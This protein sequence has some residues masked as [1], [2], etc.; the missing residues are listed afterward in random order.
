MKLH[1]SIR[2]R[3]AALFR[4]S[5]LNA[6]MDDELATR[7]VSNP[8]SGDL[9]RAHLI[10]TARLGLSTYRGKAIRDGASLSGKWA[11][12]RRAEHIII[13]AA[14]TQA[15]WERAE[16]P[17]LMVYRGI[18][19]PA[20]EELKPRAIP[21]TSATFS[22]A[23]AESHFKGPRARALFAGLGAHSFL[24]LESPVSAAFGLVLG[25][26]AHAV[27]WP[28]PQG[29]AQS[30]ADA[31]LACL[32]EAGGTVTTN[33][34][35]LSLRE[36]GHPDLTLLDVTPRQLL[37]IGGAEIPPPVSILLGLYFLKTVSDGDLGRAERVIYSRDAA[38]LLNPD[39]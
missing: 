20:Q 12:R 18:G 4:R 14:F 23:I 16:R 7:Y 30:I 2:L 6:D 34:R 9:I 13:R 33:A 11:E 38:A 15:L 24:P 8:W 17:R 37:S 35:V 27:G 36:L 10:T 5:E 19:L 29:G 3:F 26:A 22:R 21:L 32:Q 31:L 39:Q 25:V 28:I 1:D